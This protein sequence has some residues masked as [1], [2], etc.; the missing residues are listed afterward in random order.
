M[1]SRLRPHDAV[2]PLAALLVVLPLLLLGP[3]CG[4]D[5]DFHLLSWLEAAQQIAHG[6]YP[7]WAFTPALNAGEPRFLFYPPLSWALGALLGS[8]LPWKFATTAFTWLCLT[9]SGFTA[10]HLASRYNNPL[11]ATL[12]AV[13][14]LVNPYM[15]FNAFERTAYGELLAAAWFPLL[16]AAALAPEL[17]V[18]ALAAPVA[19]LWLTNV[20]AAVMGCYALALILAVRL[21]FPAAGTQTRSQTRS[22]TRFRLASTGLAAVLLGLALSAFYLVPAAFER[23]FVQAQ[24]ATGPGMRILDSTLFH[25]MLPANEGT[26]AHDHVLRQASIIATGLL[27]V[28]VGAGLALL[29]KQQI[30]RRQTTPPFLLPILVLTAVIAFFLTPLS[31]GL[32]PHVPQLVFLQFPW[33]MCALLTVAAVLLLAR[34]LPPSL[35]RSATLA[36]AFAA[37]ILF[38]LPA[39]ADYHQPC[40]DDDSIPGRLA[41]F[42]SNDGTEALDEYTPVNADDDVKPNNPAFWAYCAAG[43]EQPDADDVPPPTQPAN[44]NPIQTPGQTPAH[45][46]LTVPCPSLL[47]LNRRQYPSWRIYLNGRL[48]TP[49]TPERQDGLITVAIPQGTDSIELTFARTPDRSLG[50]G[51]SLCAGIL[52]LGL[53]LRRRPR[54]TL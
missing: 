6:G 39:W 54:L 48:L 33:R 27:I 18:V 19:L 10:R 36:L 11:P 40:D 8:V 4:H 32:W 9:L 25:I 43:H 28:I 37:V 13:L 49:R 3:S 12:A 7:H 29:R 15:L 42:H 16:F 20:P 53:G 45:F 17:N 22:Q 30:Q 41:L 35:S 1:L 5:F 31:L 46:T 2:I 23:R 50:L 14:Y 51:I 24:L 47:V 44:P 21:L 52:T 26:L 34:L 38:V